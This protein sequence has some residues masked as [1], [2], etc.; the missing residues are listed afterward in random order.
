MNSIEDCL[1]CLVET[2]SEC[3]DVRCVPS[4]LIGGGFVYRVTVTNL[5]NA[6]VYSCRD[7]SYLKAFIG[8][9]GKIKLDV[10]M[11]T[12]RTSKDV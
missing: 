9:I 11:S 10:D 6:N 4:V 2:F 12:C 3:H 1:N 8:V 7:T 5:P